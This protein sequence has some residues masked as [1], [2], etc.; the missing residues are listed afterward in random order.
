MPEDDSSRSSCESDAVI[1]D[2]AQFVIV[3]LDHENERVQIE[4]TLNGRVLLA[5]VPASHF[6][7]LTRN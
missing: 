7:A 1:P 3:N 2:G 4:F 5:W 6:N